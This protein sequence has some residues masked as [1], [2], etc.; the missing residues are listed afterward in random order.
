MRVCATYW[1]LFACPAFADSLGDLMYE[2]A[3][4]PG[5][6]VRVTAESA[7]SN[8]K[9]SR[10]IGSGTIISVPN[11]PHIHGGI[12]ILTNQH[13]IEHME[14]VFVTIPGEET[15]EVKVLG[16]DAA[17]DLA[18]LSAPDLPR[19]F[20]PAAIGDS[21]KIKAGDIVVA[22]GYPFNSHSV[23]TGRV[24]SVAPA[25]LTQL[26]FLFFEHGAI[27]NPGSSGGALYNER[28]E[29]VGINNHVWSG[30]PDILNPLNLSIR[31]SYLQK[32]LQ[33]LSAQKNV[34]HVNPRCAFALASD[35]P[36]TFFEKAGQG[37]HV[38]LSSVVVEDIEKSSP[39]F[40]AGIRVGD[41][42]TELDGERVE[43]V[44]AL[45]EKL[46]FDYH[47]GDSAV[48]TIKRGPYSYAFKYYEFAVYFTDT[49]VREDVFGGNQK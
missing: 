19:A 30:Q 32:L 6:D 28:R 44:N 33:T 47:P 5:S 38:A 11:N 34:L 7:H 27:L 16:E 3:E 15:K 31:A 35:L 40:V 1:L 43:S 17:I 2:L 42:L 23:T 45:L 13:V 39:L 46:F 24:Q 48:F 49:L 12:A 41:E 14:K 20:H 9:F 22:T 4:K 36:Q 21:T 25:Y 10:T 8:G 37:K 29:L 26:A 18:L